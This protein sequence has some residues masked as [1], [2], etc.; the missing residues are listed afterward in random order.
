MCGC[1]AQDTHERPTLVNTKIKTTHKAKKH[2]E[3][4][5]YVAIVIHSKE[6]LLQAVCRD[7]QHSYTLCTNMC[8]YVN[9]YRFLVGGLEGEFTGSIQNNSTTTHLYT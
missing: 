5:H 3:F 6:S 2:E 8:L 4:L 1:M 7:R 9:N